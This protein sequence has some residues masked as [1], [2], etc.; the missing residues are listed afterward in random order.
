MLEKQLKENNLKSQTTRRSKDLF[1]EVHHPLRNGYVSIEELVRDNSH[2]KP[3]LLQPP[4]PAAAADAQQSSHPIEL[5]AHH[6]RRSA[7][8]VPR[9]SSTA[10]QEQTHPSRRS[11]RCS[12]DFKKQN[13][14]IRNWTAGEK[15]N[16]WLIMNGRRWWWAPVSDIYIRRRTYEPKHFPIK[17]VK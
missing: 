14:W 4:A 6:W 15:K 16:E 12:R 13:E 3:G 9:L 11:W 2:N 5:R 7:S 1:P 17:N 10:E 8:P